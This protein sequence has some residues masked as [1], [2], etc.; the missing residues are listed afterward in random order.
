MAGL[1]WMAAPRRG[2]W[3]KLVA[4]GSL[5]ALGGVFAVERSMVSML[6]SNYRPCEAEQRTLQHRVAHGK[7]AWSAECL[8]PAA[9]TQHRWVAF[10]TSCWPIPAAK[11]SQLQIDAPRKLPN[12]TDQIRRCGLLPSARARHPANDTD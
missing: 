12:P 10:D 2:A 11:K 4:L 5:L 8:G 7:I 6:F 9:A 3:V 1:Q